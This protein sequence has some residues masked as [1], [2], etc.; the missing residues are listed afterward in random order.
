[1]VSLGD[2]LKREREAKGISLEEISSKTRIRMRFLQ[3]LEEDRHEGLPEPPYVEGFLRS[4]L[5]CLGID[6]TETVANYRQLVAARQPESS[7]PPARG[8]PGRRGLVPLAVIALILLWAGIYLAVMGRSDDAAPAT[9]PLPT[10]TVTPKGVPSP[11]ELASYL[12]QFEEKPFPLALQTHL[13]TWMRIQIDQDRVIEFT[14]Q[15]GQSRVLEV[16]KEA[17]IDLGN[18]GGVQIQVNG[19]DFGFLGGPGEVIKGVRVTSGGIAVTP[20]GQEG[21]ER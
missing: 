5:A 1:M 14:M 13:E 10:A 7:P 19:K 15:P 6:P 18:A 3:A 12:R 9:P 16:R 20:A 11:Q 21:A 8:R 4:Y 17:V 2:F